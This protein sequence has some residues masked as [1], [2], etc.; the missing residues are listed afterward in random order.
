MEFESFVIK[1]TILN[2]KQRKFIFLEI[3][4]DSHNPQLYS[5][6]QKLKQFGED[7]T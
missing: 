7:L 4:P 5:C 6:F 1:N 2:N 3:T